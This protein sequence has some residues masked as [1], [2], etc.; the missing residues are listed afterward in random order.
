[1]CRWRSGGR[2]HVRRWILLL[3]LAGGA[4]AQ[5]KL[6]VTVVDRKS[7]EPVTGLKTANFAV[8]DDR[9]QRNLQAAEFQKTPLDVML[10]VDTSLVGE[11]VHPLAGAF[12]D[13]L[14]E[15]EQMAIVSFASS[16]ELIQDFTS[17]RELLKR[18]VRNVKYGNTPRVVDALYAA[19]DG[20]F[21]NTV[22]R[23]VI[24]VLSAGVE[25]Y[26]RTPERDVLKLCRSN[27]ISIFS[28]YV[29]GAERSLFEKL[30]RETAGAFFSARDL[31][32]PPAKLADRVYA[33]LR[34]HYIITLADNRALGDR[35]RVEIS[36]ADPAIKVWASNLPMD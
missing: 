6:Q 22:G 17:S 2:G 1:L 14:Q 27:Q 30:A 31:K 8:F 5:T 36:G 20:G 24:V 33:V 18:A 32:L 9:T 35:V 21:Q 29:R 28:V 13:G 11:V 25:G 23:K 10:L 26:S 16:A 19:A 34:G 3:A 4:W 15:K 12:I 7:G